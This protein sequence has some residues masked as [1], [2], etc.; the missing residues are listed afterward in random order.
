MIDA[1]YTRRVNAGQLGPIAGI[2]SGTRGTEY[3][4]AF[5]SRRSTY[6][7]FS[8][9]TGYQL[10]SYVEKGKVMLAG[11][12]TQLFRQPDEDSWASS[13][14]RRETLSVDATMPRARTITYSYDPLNRLTAADYTDGTYLH[15]TYDPVG[16]RLSEE[17]VS[18]KTCYRYDDANRLERVWLK[19]VGEDCGSGDGL[20]VAYTWDNNGN[21]LS[22]GVYTYT[23][24]TANQLVSVSGAGT[25]VSYSYNGQGDRVSQT[26]GITTTNFTLDLAAGLTQVL[27]D[28]ADTYL[29][30]NGRIAQ[31][32]EA[33]PEYF[34][35]DA[36]GGVRQLTDETGEVKLAG[37]SGTFEDQSALQTCKLGQSLLKFRV[38]FAKLLAY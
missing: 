23:Y 32:S 4:D 18:G 20:G 37:R 5:V 26:V 11:Y 31:Y 36:L 24:N 13:E 29:Y 19:G 1:A 15:Y 34:L 2:D 28:G 33:G 38:I 30:G 25:T 8:Q 7:G 21:L 35:N 16:N 6:I 10:T 27:A 9:P 3:F 22:D 14:G 12:R 17:T